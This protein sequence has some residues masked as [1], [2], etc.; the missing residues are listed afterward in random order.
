[1]DNVCLG[2]LATLK[3]APVTNPVASLSTTAL[4]TTAKVL[5]FVGKVIDARVKE[6]KTVLHTRLQAE[7]VE[8]S[9]SYTV[10]LDGIK[11]TSQ[12]KTATQPE[13]EDLLALLKAKALTPG[14]VFTEVK[15]YE[16]STSKLAHAIETGKLTQEE[17]QALKKQSRAIVFDPDKSV[18]ALLES[19]LPAAKD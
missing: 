14:L 17:V 7:G 13:P 5:D 3:A 2:I 12:L 15:K 6:I 18:K 1:M 10:E 11:C 19:F 16:L 4:I 8:T 9:G